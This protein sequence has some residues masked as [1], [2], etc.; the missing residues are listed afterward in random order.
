MSQ[1]QTGTFKAKIINYT[2]SQNKSGNPQ[3]EVLFEFNDG[4]GSQV[5]GTNHQVRWWGQL[6]EKSIP[7]TLKALEVMGFRGKTDDDFAKLADGVE[8]GMLDLARD[9]S[10]VL[11]E[12]TKDGKTFVQVKWVNDPD[13]IPG[14]FK[15]ALSRGEAKV[16]I[17]ALN[18]AGQM[19]MLRSQAPAK[20]P[21]PQ[22]R[23]V[24]GPA[25]AH[26]MPP[27]REP[28]D[29]TDFDFGVA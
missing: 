20:T 23:P 6:T 16:K 13:R 3:V 21:A 12:E 17:G 26:G 19:A 1:L 24:T 18:L 2:L 7:W 25:H 5:G 22:Q 4:D 29:D 14:G 10:L 9:V 27:M 11:E 8:G 15:N 28:G